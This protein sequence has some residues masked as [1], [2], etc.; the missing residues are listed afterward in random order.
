MANRPGSR[1]TRSSK[2]RPEAPSS[3]RVGPWLLLLVAA[4]VLVYANSLKGPFSLDDVVS[5]IDNPSI[6]DW[7]NVRELLIPSQETPL[8]SRPLV[9]ATFAANYAI[10]ARNVLGYHLGNIAVHFAAALALFGVVRRLLEQPR[11]RQRLNLQGS[12][13]CPSRSASP[14]CGR[15]IR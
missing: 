6:R 14:C 10:G 5:I 3:Q 4:V 12:R 1:L 9:S 11:L 13:A 8:T 7:T 15:C 2:T